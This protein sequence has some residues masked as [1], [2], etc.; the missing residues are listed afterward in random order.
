M[1]VDMRE[2]ADVLRRAG[3]PV[4]EEGDWQHRGTGGSFDGESLMLHHDASPP[5]SSSSSADYIIDNLLSQLWLAF[6][7]TWHVIAAGRM[8][9]AGKGSWPGVPDDN[10]NATF[11]GIETDHTTNESWSHGQR[12]YGLRGILALADW[13]D[14]RDSADDLLRHLIAHKEWAPDR[15]VDPDPL[16]MDELRALILNPPQGAP[17]D[18][19]QKS[20]STDR[21]I[22]DQ[23][24]NLQFSNDPED[25]TGV[26]A[27]LKGPADWYTITVQAYITGPPTT[28]FQLRPYRTY[29]EETYK[30]A[31]RDYEMPPDGSIGVELTQQG[32][33][34]AGWWYRVQGI[35]QGGALVVTNA[36]AEVAVW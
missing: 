9:H 13:L 24:T 28:R 1:G 5:G 27:I 32:S 11:I 12:Q 36:W 14:I 7:G 34:A 31:V 22:G 35:S 2:L 18:T 4:V 8:N 17:V 21:A 23:W 29:G 16:D 15:K 19:F 6:D 25:P 10:A 33:L 3:V 20:C 26:H 30:F